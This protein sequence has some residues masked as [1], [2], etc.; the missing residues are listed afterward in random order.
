MSKS[1]R[2]QIEN[3]K[4]SDA[5]E[6]QKVNSDE[7]FFFPFRVSGERKQNGTRFREK[8]NARKARLRKS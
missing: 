7:K 3:K 1:F 2:S 8:V 5:E 6:S 4:M